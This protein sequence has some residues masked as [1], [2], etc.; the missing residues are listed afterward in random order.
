MTYDTIIIGGGPAG[1][2][3]GIYAARKKLSSIIVAESF[4]GQSIVSADIQNWIGVKSIP[5][6]D[7]A[8]ALEGHL[9]SQS[10]I[11]VRDGDRVLS[12]SEL[13][14]GNLLASLAS[15][16]T[17]EARTALIATGSVRRKLGVPG[18]HEFN[19]KGVA[20]CSICDAPMFSDQHVA[21]VG[22][23]NSAL[24]SVIDLL[25]YAA[26]VTLI[27][28]GLEL[29][30][31]RVT[32]DRVL[33]DPKVTVRYRT[34]VTEILG[35]SQVTSIR[36][37]DAETGA[38][39]E[40][41]VSGVFIE[42]GLVPAS[43]PVRALVTL[44]SYGSIVTDPKTQRTSHSRVWAAGDVTDGLYKQNNISMGDAVKAVLNLYE[45]IHIH[46]TLG[47]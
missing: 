33:T 7:F 20:Y 17:I 24:E 26:S 22:A 32:Q 45:A 1:V 42:I 38:T 21:V 34:E 35:G 16:S 37:R 29:K 12:V 27:H 10:G 31:D 18:E 47:Q 25:P 3:A 4:G 28:R 39:G 8:T 40:L 36:I 11:E 46:G 15:D 9:R 2:A 41:P 30:G 5:G 6:I 13:P 19:G 14:N 43:E 23:G 44:N